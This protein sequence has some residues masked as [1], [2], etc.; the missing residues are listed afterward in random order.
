MKTS[1]LLLS[2]WMGCGLSPVAPGTAGSVAAVAVAWG[3][4]SAFGWRPWTFAALAAVLLLPAI[5]AAGV[6]A[7]ARGSGD[8]QI[9]VVDEVIGQWVTLAGATALDWRAWLAAFLLFRVFDV[10]KP[11]P[12][13]RLERMHGGVGIVADDIGAGIYAALMLYASGWIGQF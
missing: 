4:H 10:V 7:A 3:L 9:V 12:L 6:T 11:F 13:R 8:P 1:A 2:T 5:W